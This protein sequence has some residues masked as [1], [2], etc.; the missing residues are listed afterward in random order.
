MVIWE[1][2]CGTIVLHAASKCSLSSQTLSH[3]TLFWKVRDGLI[4]YLYA[5]VFV[6]RL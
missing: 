3:R 5:S 6:H 2:D 4:D 1:W